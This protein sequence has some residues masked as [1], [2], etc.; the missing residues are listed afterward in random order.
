MDTHLKKKKNSSLGTGLGYNHL[1]IWAAS[2][3]LQLFCIRRGLTFSFPVQFSGQQVS[4]HTNSQW[5]WKFK[6]SA[7]P[8]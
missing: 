6:E 5:P 3:F 2:R 4:V 1:K 8:I 7:Y